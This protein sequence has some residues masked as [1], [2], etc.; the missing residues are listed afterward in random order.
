MRGRAAGFVLIGFVVLLLGWIPV[1]AAPLTQQAQVEITSP[2][3]GAEIRGL[4]PIMGSAS[5]PDFQY[6]KVEFGVGPSPSQWAVVGALH[7]A[8]IVN[9]QLEVWDTTA[10]PDGVYSIRLRVVKKDG[11]YDEFV[12][13][14]MAIGNTKP[15]PT[16]VP[17]QT[18]TPAVTPTPFAT[19]EPKVT[20]TPQ[21]IA[22]SGAIAMPTPT[23][24]LSRPEQRSVLRFEI[25]PETWGQAFCFGGLA[26]GAV[27]V[28]LGIVFGLRRIL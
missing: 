4:T 21:I 22:P 6:Y 20:A 1:V 13:R 16:E 28:V 25:D 18:L 17:T 24:T 26:M 10:L 19:R 12:V 27:F 14:Q 3:L 11:N 9:G 7:Q 5:L 8:P 2:E 23:P 15:T